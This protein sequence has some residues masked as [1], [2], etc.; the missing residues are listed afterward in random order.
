VEK[1][2]FVLQKQTLLKKIS[3]FALP[4]GGRETRLTI[5][6]ARASND[7]EL[8]PGNMCKAAVK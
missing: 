7:L 3:L 2:N 1:P 5:S 4:S 8:L 6:T